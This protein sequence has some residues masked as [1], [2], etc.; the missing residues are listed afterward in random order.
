MKN[1]SFPFEQLLF[2]HRDGVSCFL[3]RA[4]RYRIIGSKSAASSSLHPFNSV[5]SFCS[6]GEGLAVFEENIRSEGIFS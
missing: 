5:R 6:E 4:R 2:F 1:S 3:I